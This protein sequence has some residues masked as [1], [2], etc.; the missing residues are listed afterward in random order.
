VLRRLSGEVKQK[1]PTWQTDETFVR[2][3]G[4]QMYLFPAVHSHGQ[5]ADF[6]LSETRD[7]EAAKLLLRRAMANP[8]NALVNAEKLRASSAATIGQLAAQ[9]IVKPPFDGGAADPL[10]SPLT[11]AIHAFHSAPR[12]RSDGTVR[13]PACV[14][15]SLET[16]PEAAPAALAE[17]FRGPNSRIHCRR[18]TA[19]SRGRS[20]RLSFSRNCWLWQCGQHLG[21]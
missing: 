21:P 12:T 10:P 7:R 13:W 6:Y 8:D 4:K 18:P 1:S 20:I 15:E 17:Y 2:I 14:P 3:A 5:T 19:S 11:A 16:I 9:V